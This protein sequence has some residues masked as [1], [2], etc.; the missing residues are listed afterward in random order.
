MFDTLVAR[1]ESIVRRLVQIALGLTTVSY[2]T[3]WVARSSGHDRLFGL[4]QVLDVDQ[5]QSIS[6]WFQ[7]L[8]LAAAA[9]GLWACGEHA[10][11]GRR[12]RDWRV[13]AGIVALMSLDEQ[14][15]LHERLRMPTAWLGQYGAFQQYSW[16]IA[17]L[18]GA[19][20]VAALV[21]RFVFE[22]PASVR[23]RFIAA[24]AL[25]LAG[26]IGLEAAAGAWMLLHLPRDAAYAILPTLEELL[27]MAGMITL[28]DASL[29]V[30]S[31]PVPPA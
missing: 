21:G 18:L 23:A 28:L 9:A 25:Y 11:T 13:W 20:L 19:A 3:Q 24:A 15:G 29:R 5:E 8:V 22:L 14:V 7:V 27:E 2:L 10:A 4:V 1:R 6:T 26:A 17:G 31:E 16:I 12:R 30:L